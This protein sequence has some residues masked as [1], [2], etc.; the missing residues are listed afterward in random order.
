M[1]LFVILKRI[2]KRTNPNTPSSNTQEVKSHNDEISYLNES[3]MKSLI[4]ENYCIHYG[5]I[6]EKPEMLIDE[7]GRLVNYNGDFIS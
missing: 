2:V 4:Q 6:I 5:K 7:T 3:E 1:W